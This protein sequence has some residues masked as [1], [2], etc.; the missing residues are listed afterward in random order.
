MI[1]AL[2][3]TE[4]EETKKK[5]VIEGSETKTAKRLEKSVRKN[6]CGPRMMYA[7]QYQQNL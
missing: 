6:H 2:K 4:C 3:D 1:D 5:R 7:A